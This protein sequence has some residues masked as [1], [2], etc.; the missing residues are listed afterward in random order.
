MTLL[1]QY[2]K[3]NKHYLSAL[4]HG[5]LQ[6]FVFRNCR[7]WTQSLGVPSKSRY[8]E[9]MNWNFAGQRSLTQY[10]FMANLKKFLF[11]FIFSICFMITT[12]RSSTE[13]NSFIVK[14]QTSSH[15]GSPYCL[16]SL[17]GSRNNWT[18]LFHCTFPSLNIFTSLF[19][20]HT[21]LFQSFWMLS[22]Y[23]GKYSVSFKKNFLFYLNERT[24]TVTFILH[25]AP[26]GI[27]LS[28]GRNLFDA[29]GSNSFC[30]LLKTLIIKRMCAMKKPCRYHLATK[31][32][33]CRWG[34]FK[35]L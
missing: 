29:L 11:F 10:I 30:L 17:S 4:G 3:L 5:S 15:S 34:N 19:I 13:Q 23:T 18:D 27:H 24:C 35:F 28:S 6:K 32:L 20:M 25:T 14:M 26:S 9:S 33:H 12:Y 16:C 1:K 7:S 31:H 22:I 21:F 2:V 8:S